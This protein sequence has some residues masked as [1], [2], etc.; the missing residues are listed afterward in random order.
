MFEENKE[1]FMALGSTLRRNVARGFRTQWRLCWRADVM[2]EWQV[3]IVN[4]RGFD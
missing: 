3:S 4:R 1:Y 2:S